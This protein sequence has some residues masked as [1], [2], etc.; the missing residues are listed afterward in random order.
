MSETRKKILIADDDRG[1]LALLRV[2]C[3]DSGYETMEASNGVEAVDRAQQ[4]QPDLVLLDANMPHLDGFE[5]TRRLKANES[6]RHIPVMMLTGLTSREDRIQGIA[7]G[8]NDFL[9]KPIDQEEL[10]MRIRNNLQIKEYHDFLAHHNEILEGTVARRTRELH[11]A[12]LSLQDGI[13]KLKSSYIDTIRRLVIAAEYK[14]TDTGAHIK[15]LGR[16]PESSQMHW[17]WIPLSWIRFSTPRPCT[18]SGRSASR[19]GSFSRKGPWTRRNGR[20]SSRTPSSARGSCTGPNPSTCRWPSGSPRPT[21]R[22][23]TAAAIPGGSSGAEIPVEGRI[24]NI[25]DQYD[26]LRSRRPYKP[27]M[28]HGAALVVITKGD[29]R[30]EPCHFD[31][32][33]REAFLE[34]SSTMRVL[35]G[36]DG[37]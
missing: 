21:T 2:Y 1:V 12:L 25:C 4:Y 31:P 8:A 19:T 18:T 32:R 29:G 27:A 30:T 15:R 20:S 6:T 22:G 9:T 3:E 14:D 5:A 13:D 10:M 11:D 35:Y 36:G 24:V 33:V 17:V 23:G 7:A 37:Q 16:W 26:A 28:D 34:V